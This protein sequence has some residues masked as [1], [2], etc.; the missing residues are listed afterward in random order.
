MVFVLFLGV[1]VVGGG[2]GGGVGRVG[3]ASDQIYSYILSIAVSYTAY[4]VNVLNKTSFSNVYL[5]F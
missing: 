5:M 3:V 2:G 1:G 4:S